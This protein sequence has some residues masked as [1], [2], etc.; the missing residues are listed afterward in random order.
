MQFKADELARQK[1]QDVAMAEELVRI[2]NEREAARVADMNAR[3]AKIQAKMSRMA[4]A[5][6]EADGRAA[7]DA[8]R[9]QAE[10]E[11]LAP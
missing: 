10:L 9:A 1:A 5:Q 11:V 6:K 3:A 4:E 2:Q 7:A 8:A